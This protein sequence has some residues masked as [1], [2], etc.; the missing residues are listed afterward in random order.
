MKKPVRMDGRFILQ[1]A[2]YW[3]YYNSLVPCLGHRLP[4][5]I[6]SL[7]AQWAVSQTDLLDFAFDLWEHEGW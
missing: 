7:I 3:Y 4:P 2:S 5:E 6:I 1:R